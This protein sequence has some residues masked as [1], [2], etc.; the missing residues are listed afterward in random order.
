MA[1]SRKRLHNNIL[2]PVSKGFDEVL[3]RFRPA[4]KEGD[5]HV[6]VGRVGEDAGDA[7]CCK[8]DSVRMVFLWGMFGLLAEGRID[9]EHAGVVSSTSISRDSQT[10][11]SSP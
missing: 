5:G 1:Y 3:E 6:A 4:G 9:Q 11:V 7:C 8:K 10:S 2:I